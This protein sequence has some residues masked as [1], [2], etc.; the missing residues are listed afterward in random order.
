[1]TQSKIAVGGAV[2][3]ALALGG[4]S[5]GSVAGTPTQATSAAATSSAAAGDGPGASLAQVDTCTLMT[6]TEAATLGLPAGRPDNLGKQRECEYSVADTPTP[7]SG[8]VTIDPI[9][10][11]DQLKTPPGTD[12]AGIRKVVADGRRVNYYPAKSG[13]LCTVNIEVNKRETVYVQV[14][15]RFAGTEQP[16]CTLAEKAVGFV[17][18]RMPKK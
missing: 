13:T 10:G 5:G 12:E 9:S 11:I 15:L 4:C 1:M 8:S 18:P 16:P 14:S 7:V 2:L 3:A 6:N 17:L